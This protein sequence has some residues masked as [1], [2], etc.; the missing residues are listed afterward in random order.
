MSNQ[1]PGTV[2]VEPNRSCTAGMYKLQQQQLV[3]TGANE[4]IY[5]S[6][7][8]TNR[9]YTDSTHRAVQ[10][11]YCTAVNIRRTVW[12]CTQRNHCLQLACLDYQI[13]YS[14]DKVPQ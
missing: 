11:Y 5:T 14:S 7:E 4:P 2:L 9:E 1:I 6:L 13:Q 3:G 12:Y 10:H 8:Q